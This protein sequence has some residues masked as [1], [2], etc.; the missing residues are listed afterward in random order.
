MS[1]IVTIDELILAYRKAKADAYYSQNFV[2]NDWIEYEDELLQNL[3]K[4][5]EKINEEKFTWF[6]NKKFT[7]SYVLAPKSIDPYKPDAL[8]NTIFSS[9]AAKWQMSNDS[10]D[11]NKKSSPPTFTLRVMANNSVNLH[12]LSALWI[13]RV[14]HKLDKALSDNSFANRLRRNKNGEYNRY[15]HGSFL[16]YFQGY[17]KWR[18][19]GLNAINKGLHDKKHIL[20]LTADISSF[21]HV[22]NPDF[23]YPDSEFRKRITVENPLTPKDESI[24]NLLLGALEKWAERTPLKAGLPVGLPAS[25]IIANLALRDLDQFFEKEIVPL[26]Y[27]RYV[28]DIILVMEN[29]KGFRSIEELWKWLIKRSDNLLKVIPEKPDDPKESEGPEKSKDSEKFKAVS[30]NPTYFKKKKKENRGLIVFKN[31]KNKLFT[32]E[33]ESGKAFAASIEQQMLQR[34]SEW[35]ALPQLSEDELSIS[36]DLLTA[37]EPS[38][39]PADSLRKSDG[40]SMRRA[41]FAI[42]LRDCESY[43]RVLPPDAWEKQRKAFLNAATE[44]VLQLPLFVEMHTYLDRLIRLATSCEDYDSLKKMV[45]QIKS[46]IAS[47]HPSTQMLAFCDDDL[48]DLPLASLEETN[49]ENLWIDEIWRSIYESILIAIP[50]NATPQDIT[51]I[52]EQI[53][54]II[55]LID[56]TASNSKVNTTLL[57]I[58]IN[59]IEKIRH[60][61]L[62]YDSYRYTLLPSIARPRSYAF[63]QQPCNEPTGPIFDY[64]NSEAYKTQSSKAN[65]NELGN[66]YKGLKTVLNHASDKPQDDIPHGLFFATRPL[67]PYELCLLSRSK[68]TNDSKI[69]EDDENSVTNS[70]NKTASLKQ[71]LLATRGF[72]I[73]ELP[74]EELPVGNNGTAFKIYYNRTKKGPTSLALPSY[75]TS[76]RSLISCLSGKPNLTVKRYQQMC[77]LFNRLLKETNKIDYVLMPELSIPTSWFLSFAQKLHRSSEISLISGV[78]YFEHTPGKVANQVWMSLSHHAFGFPSFCLIQQDKQSAALHEAR[79]LK[80][81]KDLTLSPVLSWETPPII[82]HGDF[83]FSVL[84]CSELTNI[85]YRTALRGAID[86]LFVPSW[87]RDLETFTALV[88]SAALD[89]HAYIVQSNVRQ[90]GDSRIRAPYKNSWERDIIRVRG[91]INDYFVV[92]EFSYKQLRQFQNHHLSPNQP[93]KP[94]PDG[95]K[96]ANW[97]FEIPYSGVTIN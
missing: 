57:P 34:S 74:V 82:I 46:Q 33:G 60:Y 51:R 43:A 41:K 29:T 73:E 16:H 3:T 59:L 89:V 72:T 64:K 10:N 17:N 78:E 50:Y 2:I 67:S 90:Y 49:L 97:R 31:S 4:F 24:N 77:R 76:S 83:A 85:A 21:Y 62:A 54:P 37:I 1:K 70:T 35:R 65:N 71:M 12:L 75:Q 87:N 86:A 81:K 15:A 14:G 25:G 42:K 19:G 84:I 30:Y 55:K 9:P 20:V 5:L 7:G 88:E 66:I 58:N 8:N 95:F 22:V 93:Y 32:L 45:E 56:Q 48:K 40:L 53:T 38:G 96:V 36:R 91:G 23:L 92:G 69:A 26:Y 18:K 52:T 47:L 94:V 63:E 6:F 61:D 11:A 39:E 44:H 79:E 27:G 80:E 28:D 13:M 68:V